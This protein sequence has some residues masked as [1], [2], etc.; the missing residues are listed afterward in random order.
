M[1]RSRTRTYVK[2]ARQMMESGDLEQAREA[3]L[4]AV[5]ELDKAATKGVLHP[6]NVARRKSRLM[7]HLAK[8]EAGK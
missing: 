3:T 5:R 2:K 1:V 7:K 8:L 6:N 4:A